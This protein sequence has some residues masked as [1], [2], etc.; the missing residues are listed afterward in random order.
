MTP[1][2]I[3]DPDSL[4][5]QLAR[6]RGQGFATDLEEFEI[7]VNG[8]ASWVVDGLGEVAAAI[9]VSG[10]SSRLT[11]EVMVR[12]APDVVQA[13]NAV[14]VALGGDEPHRRLARILP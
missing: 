12:I 1:N 3:T 2:T 13:A 8:I 9:S 6:F 7:G 4:E 5:A 14:S 11:E 10:H